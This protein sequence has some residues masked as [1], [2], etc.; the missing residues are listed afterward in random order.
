MLRNK[1]SPQIKSCI[2]PEVA[3]FILINDDSNLKLKLRYLEGY[4][5][6]VIPLSPTNNDVPIQAVTAGKKLVGPHQVF[7]PSEPGKES[8][9]IQWATISSVQ[10]S[11]IQ[12]QIPPLKISPLKAII[13]YIYFG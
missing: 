6:E 12:N 8:T 2:V 7:F 9:M 5:G 13:P 4:T 1:L 10:P 3:Q 11:V